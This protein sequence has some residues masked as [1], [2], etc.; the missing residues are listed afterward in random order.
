MSQ[1]ELLRAHREQLRAHLAR[2]P[3]PAGYFDQGPHGLGAYEEALDLWQT[4]LL[5]LQAAARRSLAPQKKE[6]SHD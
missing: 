6:Q 1:S 5:Q 3:N 4:E 2:R